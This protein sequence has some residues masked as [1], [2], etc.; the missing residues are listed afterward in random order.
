MGL[1]S[2]FKPQAQGGA[3]PA[4]DQTQMQAPV[5]AP[6]PASAPPASN[7]TKDGYPIPAPTPRGV[8]NLRAPWALATCTSCQGLGFNTKGEPCRI[9]HI[10]ASASKLRPT[11]DHFELHPVSNGLMF[12]R[13]K[14][15]GNEGVC[16]CV[17]ITPG[18]VTQETRT[19]SPVAATAITAP[20]PAPQSAPAPAPVQ[21]YAEASATAAANAEAKKTRAKKNF[22]LCKGAVVTEGTHSPKV[23]LLADVFKKVTDA[24]AAKTGVSFW[25]MD[26]W[27]RRD[28]IS[29]EAE[30]IAEM[31]GTDHVHADA[32]MGGDIKVLYDAVAPYAMYVIHGVR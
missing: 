15:S 10:D 30:A 20:V 19:Q 7:L 8:N 4:P 2:M 14:E 24:M 13:H 23:T 27:K 6:A 3:A 28:A 16:P 29:A 22:V 5:S 31:L 9:C 18:Q 1:A 11:P 17:Q 12:W 32:D 25:S 21:T 26:T